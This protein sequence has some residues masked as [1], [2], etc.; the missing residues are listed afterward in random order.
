[1]EAM[2]VLIRGGGGAC[3]TRLTA[4]KTWSVHFETWVVT[5]GNGNLESQINKP[6]A[7]AKSGDF[8]PAGASVT[9]VPK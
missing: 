8:A 9:L 1:M 3:G 5:F 7:A 6:F 4:F 2:G